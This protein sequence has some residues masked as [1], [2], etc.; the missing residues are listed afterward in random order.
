MQ[1]FYYL[2]NIAMYI[3]KTVSPFNKPCLWG[4]VE[5]GNRFAKTFGRGYGKDENNR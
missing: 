4:L 2:L 1:R 5:G 3:Y